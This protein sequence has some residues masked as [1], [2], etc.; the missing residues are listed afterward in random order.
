MQ[1]P[2]YALGH[3]SQEL[4]RLSAQERLIGPATRRFFRDAGIRAGMRVLDVGSGAGDSAFAAADLVG[5]SGEVIGT[6]R[7]AEAVATATDRARAR[8][9]RNASFRGS[10]PVQ[11]T[12]DPPVAAGAGG[13]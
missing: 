6:D 3:S 13:D 9:L 5:E 2:V 11:I 8:G 7:A 10:G 4:E 1:D 12:F